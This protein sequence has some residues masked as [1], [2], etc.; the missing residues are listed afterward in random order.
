M[1]RDAFVA[2]DDEIDNG[3]TYYTSD[4][5]NERLAAY[6]QLAVYLDVLDGSSF[7]GSAIITVTRLHSGGAMGWNLPD[8]AWVPKMLGIL[9]ST[10][11]PDPADIGPM[12]TWS[13]AGPVWGVDTG[14]VP[15]LAFSRLA[16][17]GDGFT[18][19]RIRVFVVARDIG[20]GKPSKAS[21]RGHAA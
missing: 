5:L 18:N 4:T 7:T 3:V 8:S 17:Y 21:G 16:I 11:Q 15:T 20:S 6:D 13:N 10:M 12:V 1:L 14:V 2:F 9:S 19:A